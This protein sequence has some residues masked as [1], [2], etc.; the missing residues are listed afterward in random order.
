[1]SGCCCMVLAKYLPNLL[2]LQYNFWCKPLLSINCSSRTHCKSCSKLKIKWCESVHIIAQS[3]GL[4]AQNIFKESLQE[5]FN[6][7]NN[8]KSEVQAKLIS[9]HISLVLKSMIGSRKSF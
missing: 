5:L 6:C 3:Q 1:M 4:V 8:V 9:F 2:L 7:H